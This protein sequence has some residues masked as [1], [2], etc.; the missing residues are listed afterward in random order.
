MEKNKNK[1]L[2][3]KEVENIVK[4]LNQ[5]IKI[6]IKIILKIIIELVEKEI[7]VKKIKH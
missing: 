1:I 5:I 4:K 7:Q 3:K 2:K 6:K